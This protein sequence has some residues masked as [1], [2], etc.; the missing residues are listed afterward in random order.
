MVTVASLAILFLALILILAAQRSL[1]PG[2]IILGSF[3]LFVLWLTGLIETAI[4]LYG[5]SGNVNGNCATFVDNQKNVFRG[6][7]VGALAWL[8]QEN[9]CECKMSSFKLFL[10]NFD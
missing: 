2:V 6:Q 7:S 9:I 1:I 4:Q 8:T 5:P 3:I 10:A